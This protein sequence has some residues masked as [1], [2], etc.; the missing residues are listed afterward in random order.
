MRSAHNM[1]QIDLNFAPVDYP[2]SPSHG[3]PPFSGGNPHAGYD[4]AEHQL[5]EN[6][7]AVNHFAGNHGAENHYSGTHVTENHLAGTHS[8]ETHIAG[9]HDAENPVERL[10]FDHSKIHDPTRIMDPPNDLPSNKK[11]VSYPLTDMY[12]MRLEC[13]VNPHRIFQ[14]GVYTFDENTT[15]RLKVPS[16]NKIM[17]MPPNPQI[18]LFQNGEAYAILSNKKALLALYTYRSSEKERARVNMLTNHVSVVERDEIKEIPVGAPWQV[19]QF[20]Q[21][22]LEYPNTGLAL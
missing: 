2:E 1:G 8:A 20:Y 7:Y 18:V 3:Y 21:I 10:A 15:A 19:Q 14:F 13:N 6:P 5:L 4:F 17:K 12:F 16:S 11:D 22:T 9:N